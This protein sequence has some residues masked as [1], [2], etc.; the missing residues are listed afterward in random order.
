MSHHTQL[1]RATRTTGESTGSPFA[2]HSEA[3]VETMLQAIDA[4]SVEELFDIPSSVRFDG[5]FGIDAASE[6]EVVR[7]VAEVL[8]R[9]D[10]ATEFLGRGR[11][12][13]Y[14]PSLVDHLAD[15]SEF[16]T[17]YTQYQPEITQGFLQALFEYQSLLVELT[18]LEVANCSMYDAAT[19]LGEVATLSQRVRSVTGDRVL[20]PDVLR[21]ERRAVLENYVSGASLA[22]E[23]YPTTDGVVEPDALEDVLD[24]DVALV[25]VENPTTTGL[26]QE[27]LEE[28]GEHLAEADAM[29]CLGSDPVALSLLRTPASI[30]ADAVIGDA[31]VLGLGTAYGTSLG[32]FACK[33][34][35]LRQVPGRLVGASQDES[36]HRAYTLTLQTRE[37]HIR[38]ERA[39]SNICT[40]QA[41]VALRTAIHAAVL[42]PDGL[43]DLAKNCHRLPEALAR[44]LD[45]IEGIA[46]PVR[47]GYHFREFRASVEPDVADL[48]SELYAEGFAVHATDADTIQICVTDANENQA[49]ELVAAIEEVVA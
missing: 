6:Q 39:T 28:I 25:Y 19:A 12:D 37:Q 17:S 15:R 26:I 21:D 46:A 47:D 45:E 2:P 32:L 11:Y 40:N 9:N 35:Y 5:E 7:Q 43:V 41:W 22:V 33:E 23:E 31:S 49:E 20:V 30:G 34:E 48:V 13:H 8:G 24:G 42:G 14:V 1:S 38:R 18:G 36:G 10:S 27:H 44:E 16:L 29:F 3:D 4:E